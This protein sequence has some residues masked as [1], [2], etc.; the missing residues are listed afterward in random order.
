MMREEHMVGYQCNCCET[1]F[2]I[3]TD[4]G[5]LTIKIND[6]KLV[7]ES[8]DTSDKVNINFCPSCGKALFNIT[9]SKGRF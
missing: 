3:E 4:N 8:K 5:T 6:G 2:G 9:P 7:I 1:D